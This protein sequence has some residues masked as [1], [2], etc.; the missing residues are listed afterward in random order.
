M[1]LEPIAAPVASPAPLM[2]TVVGFEVAQAA[3]FVRFCVLP[4]LNVPVAVNCTLVPFA[5]DEFGALI[6]IDLS[7]AAVTVNVKLVEVTPFWVA[8]MLLEPI[9]FPVARPLTLMLMI[10]GFELTQVTVLV[11]FCV[12][13]SLNV[14]VAVN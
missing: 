5:I 4:S 13:P 8:V 6:V 12:L 7:V 1:L 3:V 10:A 11:R 2:L 14:P 9:A